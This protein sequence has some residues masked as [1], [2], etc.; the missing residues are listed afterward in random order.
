[1]PRRSGIR[2][3]GSKS[4]IFCHKLKTN[5]SNQTPNGQTGVHLIKNLEHSVQNVLAQKK[6][7]KKKKKK[8]FKKKK[9]INKGCVVAFW[10]KKTKKG[11][12]I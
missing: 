3:L 1:M 7:K 6:K 5:V 11:V 4:E 2:D 9:R 12:I 8:I 10:P